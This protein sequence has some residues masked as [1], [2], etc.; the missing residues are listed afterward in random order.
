MAKTSLKLQRKSSA[1]IKKL[2]VI[3]DFEIQKRQIPAFRASV[4]EKVG[5]KNILF[6]NHLEHQFVYG[7]PLIQYKTVHRNP[8]IVCINQGS[9]EILK[10]FQQ[11]DWDLLIHGKRV[12]TQIKNIVF[13]YFQCGFSTKPVSYR[14]TNWFALNE[15]NF[16]KYIAIDDNIGRISFLQRVL[17]GNI[18]SFAKGIQW[19]IDGQIKVTIPKLREG[20]LFSFKDHQM[21]GFDLDFVTNMVLPD[22]IGLGK[23]VS[24]GFGLIRRIE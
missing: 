22:F 5:R 14:I 3:F 23:S 20:R 13:D 17:T 18:L 12:K 2:V 7:Y 19:H 24:R 21:V 6:H 9:E 4:I 15:T 8:T 11:T 16:L 1:K 10:F